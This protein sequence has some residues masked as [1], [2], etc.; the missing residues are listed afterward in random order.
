M[1]ITEYK[2]SKAR[3][4]IEDSISQLMA[5]GMDKDNAAALLVVQGMIRIESQKKRQEMV[6]FAGSLLD[7]GE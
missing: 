4:I 3:D 1:K 5:L 7:Y 2:Q 6:E